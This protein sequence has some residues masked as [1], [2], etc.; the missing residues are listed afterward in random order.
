[1]Q[2]ADSAAKAGQRRNGSM[3]GGRAIKRDTS[4]A[5]SSQDTGSAGK[6]RRRRAASAPSTR[7]SAKAA[8]HDA[9]LD[10]P[11]Y[12]GGKLDLDVATAAQIHSLPGVS[13]AMARRIAA[14]RMTR[15]PFLNLDGMRRVAGV[16][17]RFV[18]QIDSL[19]TFSG[20][21]QRG[22]AADTVVPPR[23]SRGRKASAARRPP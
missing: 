13:A 14:D 5:G 1:M 8:S 15:G 21:V 11:G 20:T 7:D 9:A 4:G 2:A 12:I 17:P 16:G 10:R 3:G 19:V 22:T 23:Q 6:R 18:A